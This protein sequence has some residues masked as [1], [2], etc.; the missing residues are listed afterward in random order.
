[1]SL[2]QRV[3]TRMSRVQSRGFDQTVIKR[4]SGKLKKP[5]TIANARLAQVDNYGVALRSESGVWGYGECPTLHPVTPETPEIARDVLS[6]ATLHLLRMSEI[7]A[8]NLQ[9]MAQTRP[10]SSYPGCM[11]AVEMAIID[12]LARASGEPLYKWFGGQGSSVTTDITIPICSPT[13]AFFLARQYKERGFTT[14][15]TKIGLDT[16]EDIARLQAIQ[17]A[18]PNV[19]L[20]LDAN[21][22]YSAADALRVIAEL[23]KAGIVPILFEQPVHRDNWDGLKKVSLE[24]GVLVA[25]DESC[26][27]LDDA[28]RIIK[29]GLAPVINIKLAKTGVLQALQIIDLARASG[30]QLMIGGMVE[31][32]LAMGFS[33]HLAAGTGAFRFIDLDTP[34]LF[35]ND[36]IVGGYSLARA[37]K[38]DLH[39]ILYGNGG[40]FFLKPGQR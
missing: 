21:E 22:G 10:Y 9:Q 4:L 11:A 12:G 2:H 24:S 6:Q 25:A 35:E 27:N 23:K 32:R 1:M 33:A 19:K 26:R 38:I 40:Y 18:H 20:I 31:T 30:V 15:K 34:L 8:V 37:P 14:I 7:N 39:R 36:P 16:E 13:E 29:E 17:R 3:L 5:F 28:T